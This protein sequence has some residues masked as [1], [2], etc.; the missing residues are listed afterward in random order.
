MTPSLPQCNVRSINNPMRRSSEGKVT[1][2]GKAKGGT[3]TRV[4]KEAGRDRTSPRRRLT[5]LKKTILKENEA[6]WTELMGPPPQYAPDGLSGEHREDLMQCESNEK[7]EKSKFRIIRLD[8]LV[9]SD[10]VQDE[11]EYE[12]ILQNISD[13]S[14]QY[15][16]VVKVEIPFHRESSPSMSHCPT[17]EMSVFVS[18]STSL[19]AVKAKEGMDNRII[20]GQQI[21]ACLVG[22]YGESGD[23]NCEPSS[24]ATILVSGV[25]FLSD[26]GYVAT[27]CN[28]REVCESF[29]SVLRVY[30]PPILPKTSMA[31]QCLEVIIEYS[32]NE[33]AKAAKE[34]LQGYV[35]G[36]GRSLSSTWVYGV[37]VYGTRKD[38]VSLSEEDCAEVRV[39]FE[40]IYKAFNSSVIGK[41]NYVHYNTKSHAVHLAILWFRNA[42]DSASTIKFLTGRM[43]CDNNIMLVARG[44][45]ISNSSNV[46]G[47][48]ADDPGLHGKATEEEC[49]VL[50]AAVLSYAASK[51]ITERQANVPVGYATAVSVPRVSRVLPQ[52]CKPEISTSPISDEELNFLIKSMLLKLMGFQERARKLDPAKA[53]G[54]RRRVVF[55]LRETERGLRLG[56]VKMVIMAHDI[57]SCTSPG[58]LDDKVTDI[59]KLCKDCDIPVIY[60]LNKRKLGRALNK[61]TKVSVVGIY[62]FDGAEDEKRSIMR[63]VS[64]IDIIS[65]P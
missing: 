26:D 21:H 10:D 63:I 47:D 53:R 28:I 48:A 3:Q 36:K 64:K 57:E 23:G 32:C 18:F 15:G 9:N 11:D 46:E 33:D 44:I 2:S 20:G 41:T 52:T 5:A 37:R 8:G 1:A 34:G 4:G 7:S 40:S 22:D 54:P 59:I 55:G 31:T 51:S 58:G 14:E 49:G 30:N 42:S 19:E 25:L 62:H 39:E 6:K 61:P 45:S 13:L 56:Y 43:A 65:P 35:V 12:E 29:G 16:V 17:H 38:G 27:T 24:I 50:K 60:G